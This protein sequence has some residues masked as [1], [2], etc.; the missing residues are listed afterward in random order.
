MKFAQDASSTNSSLKDLKEDIK[1][2]T[3]GLSQFN[4]SF[5]TSVTRLSTL[6][7]SN[8]VKSAL[9]SLIDAGELQAKLSPTFDLVTRLCNDLTKKIAAAM[10]RS[11]NAGSGGVQ[12]TGETVHALQGQAVDARFRVDSH[13]WTRRG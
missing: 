1:T 5:K 13:L 6:V 4:A 7:P 11:S 8:A 3:K 10:V 12:E 9:T 2:C